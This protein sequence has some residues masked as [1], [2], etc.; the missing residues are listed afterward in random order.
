[1]NHEFIR[2]ISLIIFVIFLLSAILLFFMVHVYTDRAEEQM[3]NSNFVKAKKS[4][5]FN[6]GLVGKSMRNGLLTLAL[7]TP[8]TAVKRGL[9]AVDDVKHFPV[10]LKHVLFITWGVRFFV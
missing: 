7:L 4:L 9:L 6:I 2:L 10:G 8:N 3:K 1:M 5:Y